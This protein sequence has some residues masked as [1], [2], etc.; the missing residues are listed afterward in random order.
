MVSKILFGS[1]AAFKKE[2]TSVRGVAPRDHENET[3]QGASER[4]GKAFV[5]VIKG[6]ERLEVVR[7]NHNRISGQDGDVGATRQIIHIYPIRCNGKMH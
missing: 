1:A 3:R 7:N 5:V 4:R 2:P 6:G